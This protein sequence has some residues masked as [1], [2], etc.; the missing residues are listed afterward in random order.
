MSCDDTVTCCTNTH[1]H[2]HTLPVSAEMK[3]VSDSQMLLMSNAAVET[4]SALMLKAGRGGATRP[5]AT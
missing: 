5:A 3:L 4:L 2:T 1:T